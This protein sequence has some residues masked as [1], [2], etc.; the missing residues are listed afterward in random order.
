MMQ[1]VEV[2]ESESIVQQRIDCVYILEYY[3]DECQSLTLE[4]KVSFLNS[5]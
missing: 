5:S 1:L 3:N 4:Q 2:F